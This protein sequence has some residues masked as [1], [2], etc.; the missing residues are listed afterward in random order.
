MPFDVAID[1]LCLTEKLVDG[2][3]RLVP[4]EEFLLL[5]NQSKQHKGQHDS[6]EL[7]LVCPL[8]AF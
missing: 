1:Y 6:C 3:L 2:C 8:A 5:Q 4:V 7:L